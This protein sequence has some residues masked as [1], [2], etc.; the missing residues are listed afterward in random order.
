MF[1]EIDAQPRWTHVGAHE[2]VLWPVLCRRLQVTFTYLWT[3]FS[4]AEILVLIY[5]GGAIQYPQTVLGL[6]PRGLKRVQKHSAGA[7]GASQY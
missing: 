7:G 2:N 3:R 6:C 4:L 1:L 5:W